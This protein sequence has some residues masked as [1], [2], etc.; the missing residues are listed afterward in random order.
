[1][2]V[3]RDVQGCGCVVWQAKGMVVML[4]EMAYLMVL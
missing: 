4:V 1:M 2:F 3:V